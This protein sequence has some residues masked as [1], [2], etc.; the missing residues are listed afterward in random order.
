MRRD[1]SLNE[2]RGAWALN[3]LDHFSPPAER[4][5]DD[6]LDHACDLIANLLHYIEQG[7]GSPFLIARQAIGHYASEIVEPGG[8]GPDLVVELTLDGVEPSEAI[9]AAMTRWRSLIDEG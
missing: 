7:G 9:C 6:R 4:Q 1:F 8:Y 3:A 2:D 5:G